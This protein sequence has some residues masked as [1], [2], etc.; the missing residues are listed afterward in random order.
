[1]NEIKIQIRTRFAPSPT[2]KQHIGGFR[3]ALYSYLYAKKQNGVFIL[4]IEDTD[5]A[6]SVKG[7]VESIYDGLKWL[8]IHPEEGPREGGEYGP[9]SQSERLDMYKKFV[10]ELLDGKHAYYCFCAPERLTELKQAQSAAAKPPKYDQKCL[11]LT[12][13]EIKEKLKAGE[14]YVV[15]QKMPSEPTLTTFDELRGKTLW[16]TKDLD[17]HVLLKSDG[18]PTYHLANVVDDHLMKITHV[19]RGEEW[20]PSFPK[21]V[22]LHGAFGW[23]MPKFI[24]L[25]LILS[26]EGG[27]LSKR[28]GAVPLVDMQHQGFLPEAVVNFMAFLGW[29]PKTEQEIFSMD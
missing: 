7:S 16:Q 10:Q 18:F 6:R 23:K 21:H 25:P 11:K 3:T 12:P 26:K 17:D 5:Q 20:L 29:N 14:K 28:K 8:G 15:R 27:K 1:M 13:D 9:Y 19:F 22:A 4:R 2:G 24:H